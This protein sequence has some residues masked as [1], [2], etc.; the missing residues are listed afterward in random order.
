MI[1]TGTWLPI[2]G[3]RGRYLINCEGTINRVF[4][5]APEEEVT[6]R[7][8][9]AGY[10]TVRLSQNQQTETKIVHRLVAEVFLAN[11]KRKP[12][13]NHKNGVKTDNRLCNLEWATHAENIQHAYDHGMISRSAVSRP[14]IDTLSG[15]RFRSVREAAGFYQIPYSTCKNYLNGNRQNP[16]PLRYA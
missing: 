2:P 4:K 6:T 12:H 5:T 16:T 8:D 11:P 9:R 13:V 10:R 14:V 7:L 3:Y 15:V 1:T